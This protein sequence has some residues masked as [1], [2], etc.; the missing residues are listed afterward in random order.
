MQTLLKT[1]FDGKARKF[2]LYGN[3]DDKV[4]TVFSYNLRTMDK[5]KAGMEGC[6]WM[7]YHLDLSHQD[8]R[9]ISAIC[10][11]CKEQK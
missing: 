7:M 4:D 1:Y 8:D 3:R 9:S 5:I 2:E 10:E 11:F 6:Y